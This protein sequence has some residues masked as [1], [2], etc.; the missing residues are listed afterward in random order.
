MNI[1]ITKEADGYKCNK[2]GH[3]WIPRYTEPPKVCPAC[4]R[5]TWNEGDSKYLVSKADYD[6]IQAVIE[7]EEANG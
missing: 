5:T 7:E 4:K 6:Q 1:T 2:C 3:E